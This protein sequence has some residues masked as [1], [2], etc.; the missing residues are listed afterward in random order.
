M[1]RIWWRRL[2]FVVPHMALHGPQLSL[3]LMLKRLYPAEQ[4][5]A[6]I[7]TGSPFLELMPAPSKAK[8]WLP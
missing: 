6:L 3:T 1:T 4:M 5:R 7:Y 2:G 8:G